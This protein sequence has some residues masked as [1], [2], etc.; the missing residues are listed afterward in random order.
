MD[1]LDLTLTNIAGYTLIL[2]LLLQ[3]LS[4]RFSARE[5]ARKVIAA[6][7]ALDDELSRHLT[8][9]QTGE[10]NE[11]ASSGN[12]VS[13]RDTLNHLASLVGR[14]ASE[15]PTAAV[16]ARALRDKDL[17]HDDTAVNVWITHAQQDCLGPQRLKL[18]QLRTTAPAA[19]ISMTILG[20][21]VSAYVYSLNQIQAQMMAGIAL[22]LLTTFGSS[23]VTVIV[24]R[25]LLGTVDVTRFRSRLHAWDWVLSL[26]RSLDADR[27]P[28]SRGERG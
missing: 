7:L 20:F 4:A 12:R 2:W 18:E 14:R 1:L 25:T 21:L 26:R 5:E 6:G 15:H 22:A 17:V 19:G 10:R 16:L 3:A 28:R 11:P 9:P 24:R 8:A 13:V 23:I 27:T